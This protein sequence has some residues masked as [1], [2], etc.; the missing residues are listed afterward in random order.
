MLFAFADD[1]EWGGGG[2]TE[3]LNL[4]C[5][6][7]KL[8]CDVYC[9]FRVR[10]TGYK[11]VLNLICLSFTFLPWLC[12]PYILENKHAL[13]TRGINLTTTENHAM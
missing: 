3:N 2:A 4:L 1:D 10:V 13:R 6:S 5:D 8:A 11:N 12:V 7:G 9:K